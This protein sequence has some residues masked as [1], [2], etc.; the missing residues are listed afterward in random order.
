[1]GWDRVFVYSGKAADRYTVLFGQYEPVQ[2][3]FYEGLSKNNIN[4]NKVLWLVVSTH[5]K[6]ISQIGNVQTTT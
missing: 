6:N 4:N 3:G 2:E 5:L 1:M